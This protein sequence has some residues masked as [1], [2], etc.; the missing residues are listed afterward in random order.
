MEP[1]TRI[2]DPEQGLWGELAEA[3]QGRA[4]ARSPHCPS[5]LGLCAGIKGGCCLR[6]VLKEEL[7][8][9]SLGCEA[10]E[11]HDWGKHQSLPWHDCGLVSKSTVWC[12]SFWPLALLS[13]LGFHSWERP[14]SFRHNQ[15]LGFWACNCRG[16]M[17][18]RG[19][20]LQ[21][22]SIEAGFQPSL[23]S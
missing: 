2:A 11:L 16:R 23:S 19:S 8:P 20:S 9:L 3:G 7:G 13:L 6:C 22:R 21:L 10:F 15:G 12:G 14:A 4:Q 17:W 1:G 5:H 18:W